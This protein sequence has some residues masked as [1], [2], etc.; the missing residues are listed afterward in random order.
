MK[1]KWIEDEFLYDGSQLKSLFAY[2][3]YGIR[4][5]SCVA[6]IGGCDIPAEHMIDGEDL[7]ANE[8]IAGHRMVHFI[9]EKFHTDL[10]SAV[11]LQRLFAS[12]VKD[13]LATFSP[14]FPLRREGDDLYWGEQKLSISIATRSPVGTA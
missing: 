8:T 14:Q 1:T 6:W 3:K 13:V 4:G 12:I 10:F 7:R 9:L 5:D 11:V 2:M